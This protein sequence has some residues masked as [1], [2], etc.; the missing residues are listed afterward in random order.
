MRGMGIIMG[1]FEGAKY[2]GL[3]D[4]ETNAIIAVYP[5][6]AKGT[7]AE[8]EKSVKDWFYTTSCSAEE[9]LLN[10]YVDILSEDEVIKKL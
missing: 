6:E 1:K 5:R 9:A 7:D 10:A 3:R 4:K 8:I 2:L